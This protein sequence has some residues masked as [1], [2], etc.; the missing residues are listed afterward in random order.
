MG[1]PIG[2]GAS[3][4]PGSGAPDYSVAKPNETVNAVVSDGAGGWFIGGLF[5]RVGDVPRSRLAHLLANG[6]VDPA[7]DPNMSNASL[8]HSAGVRALALAGSRLYVGGQFTTVNGTVPRSN[9][10][11]LDTTTGAVDAGFVPD[12]DSGVFALL[13]SGGALYAGGR[14]TT[15]G[16]ATHT[17]LAR[18]DLTTGAADP[19]FTA[20]VSDDVRS[21]GRAG[22]PLYFGGS[23]STV[24][25][26]ARGQF[27]SVDAATGAL[28]TAFAPPLRGGITAIAF[29]GDVLYAGG[30]AY[31][32]ATGAIGAAPV[33]DIGGAPALLITDGYMYVGGGF[34]TVNGTSQRSL[35]R[36]ARAVPSPV[37]VTGAAS[38]VTGSSADV[39]GQVNPHGQQ[40]RYTF[41]YGPSL[42]FGSISPVVALDDADALEPVAASLT[43]LSP[44]TTYYYRL[45]A[46]NASGTTFG[47]VAA[48][49]TPGT[50]A[51]LVS[52]GA[53]S[54][55]SATGATLSATV[56][57]RG[58]ATAFTF[59][60]GPTNGFGSISAVD[61]AGSASGSQSVSLPI[62]GLTPGTEYRYRIVGGMPTA[63][64]RGPSGRSR[65]QPEADRHQP[66]RTSS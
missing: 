22:G 3:L 63:R 2:F 62:T 42:S 1:V 39:A 45:V 59:E 27:A 44:A 23:F 33:A 6:S 60:Y 55:V 7:F 54:G 5:S 31:D 12:A 8:G 34:G 4:A 47:A 29:D 43:G 20:S 57:P 19:A 51:P 41:E 56:D 40:T 21:L 66:G 36:F 24:N 46:T 25:G 11:A 30:A 38:A 10:A 16:G 17:R 35:A 48:F 50:L 58:S 18:L 65:L 64:R 14:F 26:L 13:P 61:S 52:T 53:A 32:P 49:S 9:L 15:I 37:A 28:M